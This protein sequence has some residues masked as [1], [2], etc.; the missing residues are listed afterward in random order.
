MQWNN[1]LAKDTGTLT[2]G[3]STTPSATTGDVRGTYKPSTGAS[4]GT[5]RLVYSQV[6][7]GAQVGTGATRAA[8]LGKTNA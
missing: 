7:A 1:T 3:D 8:V 6:I 2:V 5:K 4:D